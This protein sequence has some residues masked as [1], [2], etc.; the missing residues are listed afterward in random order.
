MSHPE[1]FIHDQLVEEAK[2]GIDSLYEN[3]KNKQTLNPFIVMWPVREIIWHGMPTKN[4]VAFDVPKGEA[5]KPYMEKMAKK[6]RAYA[7][8]LWKEEAQA[9]K[10]VLESKH[11]S[12][13]WT[14]PIL[15]HGNIRVLDTLEEHTDVDR[16]GIRL[17]S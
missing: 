17:T 10:G 15:K 1:R 13:T 14:I 7:V 6:V 2:A 16:L 4:A 5:I 3:W 11:G 8:L 9:L 12:V